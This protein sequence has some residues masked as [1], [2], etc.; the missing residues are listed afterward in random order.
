MKKI[1]TFFLVKINL[2]I[3]LT[4]LCVGGSAHAQTF[5]D[6]LIG[7]SSTEPAVLYS[8]DASTGKATPIVTL[9]GGASLTGLAFLQRTLYGT[10]LYNFPGSSGGNDIGSIS[11]GGIITF[12]SNQN[13]S[14]NWHGLAANE[15]GNVLYSIDLNN[16]NI[17]TAQFPDGS[18]QT[19]GS[20][21]GIDGRG[22]EYD[23]THGIL[24]ATGSDGSLYTVST[25]TGTST[26]IGLTGVDTS[27]YVGLAYDECN[28][29]LYLND[30]GQ[31]YTLDIN[32]GAA[33]LVGSNG[34]DDIIDGLAWKGD[35]GPNPNPNPN[36]NPIPTLSEWGLIV[37]A[38][39]LGIAALLVIRRRKAAV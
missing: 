23:N 31:L 9:N 28:E 25:S 11:T 18:V 10:D 24:Y 30:G 5:P 39:V 38:G 19:I 8:I 14:A 16:N 12:L 27:T 36:P 29:I 35:C 37:M 33:T 13:G 3:A 1:I 6:G 17:L 26:L 4:I 2:A 21:T 32:T 34:V 22:M 20:G 15:A 7:L